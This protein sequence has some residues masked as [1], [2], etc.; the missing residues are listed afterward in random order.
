M[1]TK[2]SEPTVKVNQSTHDG[3]SL[4][5]LTGPCGK[6]CEQTIQNAQDVRLPKKSSGAKY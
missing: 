5:V 1:A 6:D 3:Q 4:G 2:H